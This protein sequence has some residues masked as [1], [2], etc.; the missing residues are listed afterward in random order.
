IANLM[1]QIAQREKRIVL[2]VTHSLRHL[3]LYD[4]VV[5][6]YQGHLAYHG[7]SNFLF[8]YFDVQKPEELFPR[9][10]QRK[11]ADWHRSWQKHRASYS[12]DSQRDVSDEVALEEVS[13]PVSR[14]GR[15]TEDNYEHLVKKKARFDEDEPEAKDDKAETKKKKK[16]EKHEL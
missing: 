16:A 13:T 5:V 8:H 1:H 3:A 14:A 10:A 6:L 9:L 7:P 11:P 4:S 15:E 2:S 12:I